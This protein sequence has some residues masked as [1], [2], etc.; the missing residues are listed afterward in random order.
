M[1]GPGIESIASGRIRHSIGSKLCLRPWKL[2][3]SPGESEA[4]RGSGW[5]YCDRDGLFH[6]PQSVSEEQGSRMVLKKN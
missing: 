4:G 6:S 2:E 3:E 5:F 1:G